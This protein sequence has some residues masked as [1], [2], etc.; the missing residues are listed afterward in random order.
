MP[1]FDPESAA[2]AF[3]LQQ[4][5]SEFAHEIDS[6]NGLNIADLYTTDG[7]FF[8]G[9]T[10][11]K[12]HEVITKFY[13]DRLARIPSQH[14]DGV[15]VGAHTFLNMRVAIKD[16]QNATVF[17]TNVSY[18][19]EGQPPVRMTITPA[20]ITRCHMDFRLEPDGQWRIAAFIGKPLFVGDDP[21]TRQ[22][23]LK[24]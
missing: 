2:I 13:T 20:M 6:N 23:L 18:A 7:V 10:P 3:Q 14:K 8:V 17:F 22:Q 24:S 11:Y 12:G 1:Q 4:L 5:V 15:R 9:D 19:G 21:F 16:K